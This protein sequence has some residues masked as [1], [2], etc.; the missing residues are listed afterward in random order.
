M[1]MGKRVFCFLCTGKLCPFQRPKD[2]LRHLREDLFDVAGGR[3]QPVGYIPWP[4]RLWAEARQSTS[5]NSERRRFHEFEGRTFDMSLPLRFE[6]EESC[7]VQGLFDT[8]HCG[9][10]MIQPCTIS[11]WLISK[12]VV[13]DLKTVWA[14]DSDRRKTPEADER[15]KENGYERSKNSSS[16]LSDGP[17]ALRLCCSKLGMRF[18]CAICAERWSRSQPKISAT[19]WPSCEACDLGQ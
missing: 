16:C 12:L 14:T 7:Q 1:L 3:H 13:K 10:L 11:V 9:H 4:V 5:R 6:P 17:F 2:Y 18:A 19:T 15:K 8:V